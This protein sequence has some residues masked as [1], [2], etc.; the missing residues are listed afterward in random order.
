[1]RVKTMPTF[2]MIKNVAF[3]E[4]LSGN[5]EIDQFLDR[6]RM[7]QNSKRVAIVLKLKII[8]LLGHIYS[9]TRT[10]RHNGRIVIYLMIIWGNRYKGSKLHDQLF[11]QT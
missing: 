5:G 4:S 7:K 6:Q 8:Q 9:K 10:Q 1:M 11:M 2:I 3:R